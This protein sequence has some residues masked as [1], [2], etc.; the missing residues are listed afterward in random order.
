VEGL[1][2][3]FRYFPLARRRPSSFFERV[4]TVDLDIEPEEL[5]SLT[6]GVTLTLG[7]AERKIELVLGFF[8]GWVDESGSVCRFDMI[9]KFVYCE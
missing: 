6:V 1:S 3:R 7:T 8:G 2:C 4:T 9:V 5:G